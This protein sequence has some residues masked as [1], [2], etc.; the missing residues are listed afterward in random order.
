M[1]KIYTKDIHGK[2]EKTD[3]MIVDNF[4]MSGGYY[5]GVKDGA[6]IFNSDGIDA[7]IIEDENGNTITENNVT[8]KLTT[9]ELLELQS[10]V[11]EELLLGE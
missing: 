6:V 4:Y 8:K 7:F 10:Q 3:V 1:Y 11:I 9:S 5:K 2:K